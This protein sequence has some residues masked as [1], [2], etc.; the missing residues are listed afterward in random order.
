MC[1]SSCL[2]AELPHGISPELSAQLAAYHGSHTGILEHFFVQ[3][4]AESFVQYVWP[5]FFKRHGVG[6][7]QDFR[8]L[9]E[10]RNVVCVLF[11]GYI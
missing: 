4:L 3:T 7:A 1:G 8:A 11:L 6:Y 10:I 2:K 9:K 5:L